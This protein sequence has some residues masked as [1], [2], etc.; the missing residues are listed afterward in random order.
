VLALPADKTEV[1]DGCRGVLPE[2]V[3][4]LTVGP[5]LGHDLGAVSRANAGLIGLDQ[6]VQCSRVDIA[7]FHQK[8]FQRAHPECRFR[9]LGMLMVMVMVVV[10]M[11]VVMMAGPVIVIVVTHWRVSPLRSFQGIVPV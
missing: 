7:L 3:H 8:A 2:P 4:V 6:F 11:M 1:G 9:Q 5:G 10:I